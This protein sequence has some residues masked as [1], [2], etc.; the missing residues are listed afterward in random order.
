[1]TTNSTTTA[2][3][4]MKGN[5]NTASELEV[6]LDEFAART[7]KAAYAVALRH[8]ARRISGSTWNWNSGRR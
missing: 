2:R 4:H 6:R 7:H 3:K 5:C 1:M 8:G